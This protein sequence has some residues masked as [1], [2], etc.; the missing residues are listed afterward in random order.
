MTNSLVIGY[1]NDLRSDDGA[2]RVV[3][4]R[5]SALDLPGVEVR[6]VS[7]LTP[8]LALEITRFDLVIFVD[9]SVDVTETTTTPVRAAPTQPAAMTHYAS[10]ESLLGMTAT[11]GPVPAR[12]YAV[13][14]PVSD[15]GLGFDLTPG[16][17][18]GVEAA[19]SA[20]TT[21]LTK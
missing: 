3:A 9:A 10:P 21:I 2:G 6:A 7:Q 4:A 12:V 14:I 20:I 11:I 15:L 8:E 19:V 17:E 5:V 13:S 16:T 18:L 1:G